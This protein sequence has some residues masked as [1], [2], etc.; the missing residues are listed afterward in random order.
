MI[1]V[2]KQVWNI[3]KMVEETN[4]TI[5][6]MEGTILKASNNHWTMNVTNISKDLWSLVQSNMENKV[7]QIQRMLAD[8]LDSCKERGNKYMDNNINKIQELYKEEEKQ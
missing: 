7:Y 1:D 2:Q 3:I 8:E 5:T 6:K 4:I